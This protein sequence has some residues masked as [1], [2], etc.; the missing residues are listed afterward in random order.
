MV[1]SE[2]VISYAVSLLT[3]MLFRGIFLLCS[4]Y[5]T[6]ISKLLLFQWAMD[7]SFFGLYST[8][9]SRPYD[10][11]VYCYYEYGAIDCDRLPYRWSKKI[12]WN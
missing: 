10:D 12:F 7:F 9:K 5:I 3:I 4:Y 1:R 2:T 6:L 8:P 11:P